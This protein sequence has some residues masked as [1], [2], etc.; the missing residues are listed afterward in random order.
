MT[1]RKIC[2]VLG[3]RPEAIKLA[4]V[5]RALKDTPD[6]EPEVIITGQHRDMV[7]PI[8]AHFCIE[9]D[10][11]L[12]IME[13]GQDVTDI[14]TKTLQGMCQTGLDTSDGVIVQGDTASAFSAALAGFYSRK[15]VFHV[16]AGLRT[17]DKANPWPEETNRRLISHLADV[18]FAATPTNR[19]NLLK[20]G[21][22]PTSIFVTGNPVIDALQ[23]ILKNAQPPKLVQD[24][25]N[26]V[27]QGGKLIVL[28]THRRENLGE[29]QKNIF[30]AV[31]DILEAHPEVYLVFPAHPNP[32]VQN[33]VSHFLKPHPRLKIAEPLNYFSF[34]H[35]L[36]GAWLVLSDSGGLQEEAPAIGKPIVVLRKVTERPEIIDAGHGVLAGTDRN[37]IV[38]TVSSIIGDTAKYQAMSAT[39]TLF[40]DGN[41]AGHIVEAMRKSFADGII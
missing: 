5:I 35:L 3:T 6:F 8:L 26:W 12:D 30:K 24:W 39:S 34:L 23:S 19:E 16:E 36:S 37:T 11:D 25:L 10:H 28:T 21:I 9:A 29:P 17:Y 15:P 2:V 20:E 7:K 18:H 41:A 1:K 40:G 4:P 22:D 31:G 32:A 27:P 33:A 13:P 38:Q 14:T